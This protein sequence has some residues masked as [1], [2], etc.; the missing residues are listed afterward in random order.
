MKS[1]EIPG[2]DVYPHV[3]R[4]FREHID[5]QFDDLRVMLHLPTNEFAA[6]CNF[7]VA[8]LLM[9]LI[10]GF[11]VVLYDDPDPSMP[12]A[13]EP[14]MR[15]PR[16]C[17][18]VRD[19]FPHDPQIEPA[20]RTFIDILYRFTRNSL[21]HALGLRQPTLEPEIK[22]RKGP[23]K[24]QQIEELERSK[25]RP[26]WV[27]G[28]VKASGTRSYDL[29]VPPLYWGTFRMLEALVADPLHDICR[30]G[31]AERNMGS[32]SVGATSRGLC[33][34]HPLDQGEACGAGRSRSCKL[35]QAG[36]VGSPGQPAPFEP[37]ASATSMVPVV[38]R[39]FRRMGV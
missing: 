34:L 14:G 19:Y 25:A 1:S 26:T 31:V 12:A 4:I 11:S 29:S 36:S 3:Q 16:F 33:Q 5:M 28:T 2:L 21:T 37:A 27:G 13:T 24:P 15:G 39:R 10:S 35:I 20:K 22:I 6:G 9:N 8:S 17:H 30:A 23:L 32:L 18:L 7:A 38:T